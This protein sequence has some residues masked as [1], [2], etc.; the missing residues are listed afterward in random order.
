MY[1]GLNGVVVGGKIEEMEGGDVLA[2]SKQNVHDSPIC[3]HRF[4]L[5]D[6]YGQNLAGCTGGYHTIRQCSGLSTGVSSLGGGP[7]Y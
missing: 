4:R 3:S 2:V 5:S 6:G 7:S 1:N